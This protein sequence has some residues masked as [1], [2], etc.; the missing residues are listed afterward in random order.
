MTEMILT[1][2][3]GKAKPRKEFFNFGHFGH[4]CFRQTPKIYHIYPEGTPLNGVEWQ[5]DFRYT[6]FAHMPPNF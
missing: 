6:P 3:E 2:S 1:E 5:P 4:I